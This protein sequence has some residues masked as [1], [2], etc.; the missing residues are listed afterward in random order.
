MKCSS[1]R[2]RFRLVLALATWA[3]LLC[4][5]PGCFDPHSWVQKEKPW[6]Q[7]TVAGQN[8]VR[9]ERE[10]GTRLTLDD[11]RIRHE[12]QGDILTG[13]DE[14]GGKQRIEIRLANVRTLEVRE[15]DSGKMTSGIVIGLVALVAIGL[16]LFGPF[17]P[18]A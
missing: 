14:S 3:F 8:R 9:V 11:P 2:Q 13:R 17:S 5:M 6:D 15:L 1:S 4:L 10:D 7:G 16:Y 12:D 18:S